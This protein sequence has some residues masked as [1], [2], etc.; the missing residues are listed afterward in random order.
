MSKIA[1]LLIGIVTLGILAGGV[2]MAYGWWLLQPVDAAQTE[3]TRFTVAKGQG[4]ITIG[5]RLQEAG[6]I[7]HPQ[8]FRLV[9]RQQGLTDKIQA[10]S[11]ELSP[12]MTLLEI[13]EKLTE[14]TDDVWI[15]VVEGWRAEEI[16][17]MMVDQGFTEFDKAKFLELAHGAEGR[18]YPDTYLVPRMITAES[19]VSLLTNTFE[20]KITQ[21][22]A[23]EFEASDL[24][25][26]ENIILASIVEREARG[27]EDMRNVAGILKNRLKINMALQADATLQYAKG[28]NAAQQ[29]WWA[30]PLAADKELNSPFN[31]YKNPGLPPRPISNPGMDAIRA[32][33]NPV[34]SDNLFYIHDLKGMPHYAKTLDEHNE[35]VNEYLR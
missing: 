33:L 14:G 1:K 24:T 3:M 10:G 23:D 26:Q 29:D 5:E 6:L 28:Y 21:G 25:Q 2:V 15:T 12:S 31:T 32:V 8:A 11:F 13:A 7:K 34:E 17:E 9:V 22:L 30:E 18:L 16:A 27:P 20:K 19:L 35:N 4:P